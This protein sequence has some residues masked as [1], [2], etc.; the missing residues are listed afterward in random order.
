VTAFPRYAGAKTSWTNS[1]NEVD[2]LFSRERG[3]CAARTPALIAL[4][5]SMYTPAFFGGI[6]GGR[7]QT[8]PWK[9]DARYNA[10]ELSRRIEAI[11]NLRSRIKLTRQ[12][13]LKFLI[14][15]VHRWPRQTLILTL[16][17]PTMPKGA[18]STTTIISLRIIETFLNSSPKK[19]INKNGSFHMTT[20]L[21]F[22][23]SINA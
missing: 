2:V 6:I 12:D 10:K 15:G 18:S 9:I 14:A 20:C 3:S 7:D 22:V 13:A 21:R 11:A 8:G 19:L 23:A 1:S 17:L 5:I 16:I 4:N